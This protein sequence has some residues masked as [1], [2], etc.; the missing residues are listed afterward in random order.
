MGATWKKGFNPDVILEKLK[1]IRTL[2]GQS[3]MFSGLEYNE[4]IHVLKS[5]I[6]V[7]K[8][9]SP[10]IANELI[11]KGFHEAAKNPVL[12]QK[13]VITAVAK[14]V[15]EHLGKPNTPYWLLTTTNISTKTDLPGYRVNGCTINFYKNLPKKYS[16]ARHAALSELSSWLTDRD[17]ILSHYVVAQ[18]SEK[19]AH[20]AVERMLDAIDLLRGIW[21]LHTNKSMVIS[22][23]GRK[24]PINQITLGAL[25]TLHDKSGA[26]ACDTFWYEPD[27]FKNH[28]KVDFSKNGYKTLDF[29]NNV[30]KALKRNNYAKEIQQ[31]IIRYTRALDS[32]DYN[33]VF[34]KLWAV[35]ESLTHTL[36]D[37][38]D[39][40]IRRAAFLHVDPEYHRQVLEHLRQYRNRSI[41]QGAGE[42]YIDTHVYQL[43]SYVERLLLFHIRNRFRFESIE[44]ATR[45]MDL[46][47][48]EAALRREITL[49]QA[50]IKFIR[51]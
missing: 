41:H 14:A 12:S 49:L 37:S 47:P 48:D 18:I 40:T 44:D 1:A 26:K 7:G 23:G 32:Q 20:E 31:E 50:G 3:L 10:D 11:V 45:L 51:E 33:A 6:D 21:N 2:D 8:G 46:R 28:A 34:I 42:N 15:R 24:K 27:F 25:H 22:F 43:K 29:T 35:L 30:R 4:Y 39:K 13:D 36:K 38:Y 16:K 5:M 9:I 19:S 17:E